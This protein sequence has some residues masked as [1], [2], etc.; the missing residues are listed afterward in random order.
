MKDQHV[1]YK[2][3]N[4]CASEI[5]FDIINGVIRNVEIIGG[6]GGN[7]R[8][9]AVLAEGMK[10]ED[11]AYRLNGIDCH[12]G[13]SCPSELANAIKQILEQDN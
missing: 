2:P 12:G 10:P 5:Q 1:V 7:T 6:C 9:L 11:I 3:K 4:V 8:G 13:F